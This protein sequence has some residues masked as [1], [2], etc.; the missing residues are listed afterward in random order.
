MATQTRKASS[1]PPAEPPSA[2]T[3]CMEVSAQTASTAPSAMSILPCANTNISP[4]HMIISG[5]SWLMME[6]TLNLEKILP[7]VETE[8]TNK[9]AISS[10]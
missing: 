3:I 10:P 4:T 8:N 9:T 1:T 2:L 7:F 5:V 6:D